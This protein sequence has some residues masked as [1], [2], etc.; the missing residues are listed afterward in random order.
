MCDE[1]EHDFMAFVEWAEQN[2]YEKGLTIDRIDNNKGYS[3]ENCRWIPR[4]DQN[5]NKRNVKLYDGETLPDFCKRT[6]LNYSVMSEKIH[7]GFS[8]EE[9]VCEALTHKIDRDFGSKCAENGVKRETVRARIRKGI[10]P[11]I[12]LQKN[13]AL[14]I[15]VNGE[16]K[17]LSDWCRIYGITTAAVYYRVKKCGMSYQDAITKPKSW[18]KK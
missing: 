6:G 4:G 18:H 1:W 9:A 10:P 3:P 8:F 12:A 16:I 17:K 14:G 5:K 11:E 15:E 2:G 7:E 13:G